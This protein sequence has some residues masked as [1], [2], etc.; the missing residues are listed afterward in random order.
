MAYLGSHTGRGA[1]HTARLLISCPDGPGIVAAVSRF[2]FERGANIVSSAQSSTHPERGPFFIRCAFS[3]PAIEGERD[4]FE[5]SFGELAQR[6][7][8][9]WRLSYASA[10][11]RVALMAS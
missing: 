3:L 11:R 2:L 10:R 7:S 9:T 5:T 1:D 4:E 6:F 8:M